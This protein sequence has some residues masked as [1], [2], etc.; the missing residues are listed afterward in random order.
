MNNAVKKIATIG[1]IILSLLIVVFFLFYQEY[2][3]THKREARV[4]ETTKLAEN[5]LNKTVYQAL[6]RDA[7]E[8]TDRVALEIRQN[9]ISNYGDNL[10]KFGDD[11][12]N[13]TEN[14]ILVKTID[15]VINSDKNR[16]FYVE[17]DAND[18]F[19]LSTKRV[20]ADQ[21]N[22]CSVEDGV[23]RMLE[24]EI[25]SHYNPRLARQSIE[26]LING[27]DSHLF[28][29]YK[30]TTKTNDIGLKEMDIDKVLKLPLSQ[31]KDYEFL[32]VSY[33]DKYGDILG[34]KDVS[35]M[36]SKN[37]TKKLMI[38]QGF[39]LY[40]QIESEFKSSYTRIYKNEKMQLAIIEESRRE[41]ATKLFVMVFLV[42]VSFVSMAIVQ[43]IYIK[44]CGANDNSK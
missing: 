2:E 8:K 14:T 5:E 23:V 16:F 31:L 17:S 11:Y 28:W 22:D 20:I 24:D 34:D 26:G 15:D 18:M 13:P 42:L 6:K 25:P 39:N 10:D 37:D 44:G 32:T 33:I 12:N 30:N 1:M 43:D 27:S 36:G 41:I 38:V 29:R 4:I 19:A 9:L 35:L 40:E 3:Y 7:Q 21:S